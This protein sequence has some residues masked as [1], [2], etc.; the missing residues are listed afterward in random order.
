M[1]S[2]YI[3]GPMRGVP[4]YNYPAFMAAAKLLR[5]LR[6]TVYNP[7]EMDIEAEPEEDWTT[8]SLE[9][10][11]LHNTASNIRRF[12]IRDIYVLL[13]K[14]RAEN[15]DAIFVLPGWEDSEGA[16]AETGVARWVMIPIIPIEWVK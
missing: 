6:W 15:G 5:G 11:K 12:A 1:K 9:Q 16:I 8:L 3:A 2:C 7:A 4:E 13:H 10:Q 14:L